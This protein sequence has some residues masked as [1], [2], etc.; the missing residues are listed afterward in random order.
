MY[1][2]KYRQYIDEI[3]E[4]KTLV[5]FSFNQ[6]VILRFYIAYK[7]EKVTVFSFQ[8]S[9]QNMTNNQIKILVSV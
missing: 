7:W 9:V 2:L 5:F 4:Y 8:P 1:I 3:H 6:F